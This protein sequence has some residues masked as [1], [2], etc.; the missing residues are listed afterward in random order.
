MFTVGKNTHGYEGY[1]A[2]CIKNGIT[3]LGCWARMRAE[4]SSKHKKTQPKGKI[5]KADQALAYIQQLY[6]IEQSVKDQNADKKYQARQQ[7][8]KVILD[9]L[10][11]WLD[12]S[13]S[14]VPPKTALGKAL[15]YVDS[16]W[17]RL[18]NYM[19]CGDYREWHRL[20]QR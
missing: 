7:Q 4:D 10:K 14:Q 2:T 19:Q 12:K 13:L 16:Q 8:S 17:L 6:R 3:R 15:Y 1:N 5:G 11:H 9:K 20:A 18:I